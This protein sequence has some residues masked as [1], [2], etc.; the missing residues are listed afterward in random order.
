[1]YRYGV[2]IQFSVHCAM[3]SVHSMDQRSIHGYQVLQTKRKFTSIDTRSLALDNHITITY[4]LLLDP[5]PFVLPS[6]D[7]VNQAATWPSL[8]PILSIFAV[9]LTHA[10]SQIILPDSIRL[11]RPLFRVLATEQRCSIC[12]Q[13]Y[14]FHLVNAIRFVN[15]ALVGKWR[16]SGRHFCWRN[17]IQSIQRQLIHHFYIRNGRKWR[18]KNHSINSVSVRTVRE[19]WVFSWRGWNSFD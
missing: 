11:C 18:V 17:A 16:W 13:K 19:S 6:I 9:N 10:R 7:R 15:C 4:H 3:K 2:V 8:V 5:M 14:N 1:M 12:F